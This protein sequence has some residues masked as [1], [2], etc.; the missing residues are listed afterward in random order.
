MGIPKKNQNSPQADSQSDPKDPP[1]ADSQSDPKEEQKSSKSTLILAILGGVVVLAVGGWF[2][3]RACGA[4][5]HEADS[6]S[7]VSQAEPVS[8]QAPTEVISPLDDVFI[9]TVS[10]PR[11][12][13]TLVYNGY[14]FTFQGA[15]V[16][17]KVNSETTGDKYVFD[18][19]G[20]QRGWRLLKVDGKEHSY[21]KATRECRLPGGPL[22]PVEKE[23]DYADFDAATKGH[24]ND[25][26]FT[27]ELVFDTGRHR[28][29]SCPDHPELREVERRVM[30]P[31]H[32][33][34]AC[35][36][37]M[38]GKLYKCPSCTQ[39]K[40]QGCAGKYED[41]EIRE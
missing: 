4:T 31:D 22:Y 24:A 28:C 9:K 34:C 18:T 17:I 13:H 29:F 38:H 33:C 25:G 3:H 36:E 5:E 2:L 26:T 35:R 21:R 1:Q 23:E 6:D 32:F 15:C 40:C 14:G 7:V 10:I 39:H 11:K 12:P 19:F 16:V 20:I 8:Q 41:G 30:Q 37:W 27:C